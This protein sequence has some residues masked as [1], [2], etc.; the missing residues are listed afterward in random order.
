MNKHQQRVQRLRK[1]KGTYICIPVRSKRHANQI[2]LAIR[3]AGISFDDGFWTTY[4]KFK[5]FWIIYRHGS[6]GLY[7]HSGANNPLLIN[8]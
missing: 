2:G 4:K 3:D 1:L 6:A 7:D 5:K 8:L